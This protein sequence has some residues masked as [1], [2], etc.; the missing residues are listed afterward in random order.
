MLF[1][2]I[3]ADRFIENGIKRAEIYADY[4]EFI[5]THKL[6][7]TSSLIDVKSESSLVPSIYM[8]AI[9]LGF[10]F[11][12]VSSKTKEIMRP[13]IRI[14]KGLEIKNQIFKPPKNIYLPK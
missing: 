7:N 6:V 4:P 8:L 5:R 12:L 13:V 11:L 3:S 9:V 14:L 1:K 2:A 10:G